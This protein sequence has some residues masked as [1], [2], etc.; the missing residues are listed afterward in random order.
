LTL[1]L[2]SNDVPDPVKRAGGAKGARR[3]RTRRR[4]IDAAHSLFVDHG[5]AGTTFEA[6][7]SAAGVA[8]QTVYFHFGNK[9]TLL[10]EVVDVAS[11]GDDEPIPLLERPWVREL[12]R[13]NDAGS[14]LA[15]W[16]ANTRT[17]Y[18]RVAGVLAAVHDAAGSDPEMAEQWATNQHQRLVAFTHLAR[19]LSKTGQL[20][21]GMSPARA[22][23][24]IFAVLSPEVFELLTRERRWSPAAWQEW[25]TTTLE[26]ALLR[27]E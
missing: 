21:P 18:E 22:A 24:L 19:L 12:D 27:Q 25:M 1:E 16:V 10:K 15:G 26:A 11:V 14:V 2:Y 17:I 4:I 23:D 6:V 20:R 8:V 13:S 5:Y 9:R 3:D 7:A